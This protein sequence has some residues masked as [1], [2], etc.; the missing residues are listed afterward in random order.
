M[1]SFTEYNKRIDEHRKIWS[2]RDKSPWERSYWDKLMAGETYGQIT[3]EERARRVY[4]DDYLFYVLAKVER[5]DEK[6]RFEYVC[7]KSPFPYDEKK[8]KEILGVDSW[9]AFKRYVYGNFIRYGK[10]RLFERL[11]R[12]YGQDANIT[13]MA[14]PKWLLK[15]DDP[16]YKPWMLLALR[17]CHDERTLGAY[18]D[19]GL[20][21]Y[22]KKF[23]EMTK[24]EKEAG[25][26]NTEGQ[27]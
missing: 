14:S 19:F 17:F 18:Y 24:L 8:T 23:D 3:S 13:I 15:M 20:E 12:K 26:N 9:E 4:K 10:P 27:E 6:T 21:D 5:P 1:I 22:I 16:D 25:N 2:L 7:T 11:K